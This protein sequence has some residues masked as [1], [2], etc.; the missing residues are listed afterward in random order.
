[1]AAA[2]WAGIIA[3]NLGLQNF[4]SLPLMDGLSQ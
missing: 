4:G 1:M 3:A 2:A